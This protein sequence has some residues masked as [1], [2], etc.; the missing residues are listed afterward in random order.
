MFKFL[1]ELND[2]SSFYNRLTIELF[3]TSSDI[4]K[5]DIRLENFRNEKSLQETLM[6]ICADIV[7]GKIFAK[8][9]QNRKTTNFDS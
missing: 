7:A 5:R 4:E 9:Y 2:G 3:T 1:A 8:A 6:H